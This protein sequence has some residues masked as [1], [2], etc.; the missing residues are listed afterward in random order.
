MQSADDDIV[1]NGL[2]SSFKHTD[3]VF[4]GSITRSWVP[5][6][7][8]LLEEYRALPKLDKGL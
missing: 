7:L 2:Q 6:A 5:V 3:M 8:P 1:V 4:T